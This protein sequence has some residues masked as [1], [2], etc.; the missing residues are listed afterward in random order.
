MSQSIDFER[1]VLGAVLL[2]PRTFAEAAEIL[3]AA[4]FQSEPCRL[5]WQAFARLQQK[6]RKLTLVSLK[7]ELKRSGQ[8]NAAG[9]P[10]WI[11][12]LV[13]GVPRQT[14][15]VYYARLVKEAASLRRLR[16]S[17]TRI[18]ADF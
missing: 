4:D 2:H 8:L 6:R 7:D 17:A 14:P 11:C 12:A 3:D 13:D 16:A 9:G 1:S 18:L 5:V 15:T 10:A